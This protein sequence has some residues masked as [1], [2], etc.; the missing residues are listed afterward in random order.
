MKW[1]SI[2]KEICNRL[3]LRKIGN[4]KLDRNPFLKPLLAGRHPKPAKKKPATCK[5]AG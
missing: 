4:L 1:G 2:K 3:Q 5:I